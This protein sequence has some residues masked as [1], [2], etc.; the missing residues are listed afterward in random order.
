MQ[1]TGERLEITARIGKPYQ[2]SPQGL[3][4][5][6]RLDGLC[7]LDKVYG[8]N[9]LQALCLGT[10]LLRSLLTNFIEKGGRLY[11]PYTDQD[12]DISATFSS[13]GK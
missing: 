10:A 5:P 13:V 1:P 11:Y 4:C 2:T 9:L 8:A 3:A 12:F 7:S 6:I